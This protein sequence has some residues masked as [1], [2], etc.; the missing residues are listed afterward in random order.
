MWIVIFFGS[1][2]TFCRTNLSSSGKRKT[3]PPSFPVRFW[4]GGQPAIPV[5][6]VIFREE[7]IGKV[8]KMTI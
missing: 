6:I 2:F 4:I 3:K 5:I 8:G 7:M 1:Y